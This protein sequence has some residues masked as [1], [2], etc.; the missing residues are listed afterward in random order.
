MNGYGFWSVIPIIIV[1]A[2]AFWKKNV[3]L[4]LAPG[5][6]HHLLLSDPQQAI[7]FPLSMR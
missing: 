2:I 7:F 4:A 6:Q 5:L 3:F 1:L